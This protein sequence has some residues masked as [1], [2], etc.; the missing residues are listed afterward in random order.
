MQQ[1]E[2]ALRQLGVSLSG[3]S[4]HSHLSFTPQGKLIGCYGRA[5]YS[6]PRTDF[7]T[8]RQQKEQQQH[9][10]QPKQQQQQ[11]QHPSPQRSRQEKQCQQRR[12]NLHVPRQ[13]LR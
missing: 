7:A 12:H 13:M 6:K 9:G 2:T 5:L 4:S 10:E 3:I 1:G 11:Q 8:Q